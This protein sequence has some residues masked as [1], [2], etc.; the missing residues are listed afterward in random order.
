MIK[1]FLIALLFITALTTQAQDDDYKAYGAYIFDLVLYGSN[2][3]QDEFID[4]TEYTAYIDRLNNLPEHIR[5]EIKYDATRSYN[6]VRLD[7]EAECARIIQLYKQS[8]ATGATFRFDMC[9][10]EPSKNFPNIGFITCYYT[11][12]LPD[13]EEPE[14]DALRFE[15]INTP[16]GWRILDGFFDAT[17]PWSW[18]S[19]LALNRKRKPWAR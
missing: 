9:E 5:E 1:P 19:F 11:V 8:A 18:S 6:E 7:Y 2:Q 15:C 4:L 12:N 10:F 17:N 13:E 3:L 14:G 16:N